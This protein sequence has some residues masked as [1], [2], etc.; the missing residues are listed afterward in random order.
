MVNLQRLVIKL[1]VNKNEIREAHSMMNNLL[2]DSPKSYHQSKVFRNIC[3]SVK[4][5]FGGEAWK[6]V[7]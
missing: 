5:K 1:K 3:L 6:H 2:F 4:I 7:L